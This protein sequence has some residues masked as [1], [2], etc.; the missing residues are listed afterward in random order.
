MNYF[1]AKESSIPSTEAMKKR[2]FV[3][4]AGDE[5]VQGASQC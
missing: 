5:Q 2:K 1:S 4:S 3:T